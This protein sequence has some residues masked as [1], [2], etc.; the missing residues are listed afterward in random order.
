MDMVHISKVYKQQLTHQTIQG[1]FI[2]L[3]VKDP[4]TLK[5]YKAVTYKESTKL[6]FPKFIT[7]YLAENELQAFAG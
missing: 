1:R 7:G 3:K 5:D 2:Q 4:L 6:P